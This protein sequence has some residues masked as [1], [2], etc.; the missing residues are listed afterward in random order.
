MKI[1]K[2]AVKKSKPHRKTVVDANWLD[3]HDWMLRSSNNGVSYNGFEWVIGKWITA[4]DWNSRP[5]CGGGFH[6]NSPAGHG[7]GFD[8]CRIELCETKGQQVVI[9]KDK[10][11]V[12]TAQIVAIAPDIPDEAFIQCGYKIFRPSDGD[13]ISP[14][15]GELYIIT[16]G[17]VIV[18]GQSGG[19]C[20]FYGSSSG[21]V[22]GQS[23]GDCRFYGSSSGTVS[24]QSGG[25]CRFDGSSKQINLT[26][27]REKDH[28]PCVVAAKLENLA[29]T[30]RNQ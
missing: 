6:G 16:D 25:Y 4:P 12:A 26:A 10:V 1:K 21:T 29:A 15:V 17:H 18:S 24:G 14:G 9:D 11:K 5:E 30:I 3:T 23:G 2:Q 19:D 20:R 27:D 22:S 28:P 8:Y 13:A 7:Y